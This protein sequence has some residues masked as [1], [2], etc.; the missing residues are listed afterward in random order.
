MIQIENLDFSKNN[1]LI[2]AIIQHAVSGEVL[3]LGYMN[4]EALQNTLREGMV[5]FYSRT[6]NKL[7]K[8][9]ETSGNYLYI[10][11]IY[12]DCDNDSLLILAEPKGPVCHTGAYTCFYTV[13][14][15]AVSQLPWILEKIIMQRV[16]QPTNNSYTVTLISMGLEKIAQKVGEE[17]IET[18]IAA[19]R[20]NNEETIYETAD[21]F[22]HLTVMLHTLSLTWADI[23]RE[24][25]RR[26]E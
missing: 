5:W 12:S 23:Y 3:M 2:P 26:M 25:Y 24:L 20:K 6:R 1:G 14:S 22:Y 11:E 16:M 4:A 10:K 13:N 21:L 19:I 8:K 17:A 18:V 7:W 9:G 15:P